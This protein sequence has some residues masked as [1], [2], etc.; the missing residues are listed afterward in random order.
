MNKLDKRIYKALI[1]L[2]DKKIDKILKMKTEKS[3]IYNRYVPEQMEDMLHI[4]GYISFD[5]SRKDSHETTVTLKG[6]EQL[7][8]LEDIKIKNK[9]IN[10][11][12]I[13]LIISILALVK[14][15]GWI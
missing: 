12:I 8:I 3:E 2:S 1:F 9:A 15:L 6:V 10:L 5:K 11:S 14:S 13:A 7:R 4:V